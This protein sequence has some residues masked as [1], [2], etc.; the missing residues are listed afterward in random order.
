MHRAPLLLALV[1]FLCLTS[2]AARRQPILDQPEVLHIVLVK[3]KSVSD[4][5]AL[6]NDTQSTLGLTSETHALTPGV[7]LGIERPEVDDD[8]TVAFIMEFRDPASYQRY[9]DSEPHKALVGRW[10]PRVESLRAFDVQRA[11][12]RSASNTSKTY[13]G[14]AMRERRSWIENITVPSKMK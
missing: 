10:M 12:A 1:T 3:L 7:A 8:Y 4:A 14:G 5:Q 11:Y 13:G 9:L 6:V 2:C